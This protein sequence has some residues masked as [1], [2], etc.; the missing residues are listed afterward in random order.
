MG[1]DFGENIKT[2]RKQ[3]GFTQE[4]VA[5]CLDVS[6]QAVSRWENNTTYPDITFLPKLAS[7]YEVTVD[8]LLGADYETNN[9]LIAEYVKNRQEA[10]HQGNMSEAFAYRK[11][12]MLY[13]QTIS[14]SSTT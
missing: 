11:K 8:F 2:L 6:K 9:T 5:E 3:R 7:F 10:H 1:F 13:F 12:Y 14:I 4:Q